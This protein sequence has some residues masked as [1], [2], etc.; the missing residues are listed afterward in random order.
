MIQKEGPGWR[1]ARDE[2][3]FPFTVLIGGENWSCEL[4]YEEWCGMALVVFELIDQYQKLTNQLCPEEHICLE[5]ERLPW[6]GC[7]DGDRASWTL[8]LILQG[9]GENLRGL[10]IC[11]PIP[12]A[13]AMASA[14][15]TMW[16]SDQ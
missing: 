5:L 4:T 14:M 6:W 12:S 13:Q 2:A 8:Q 3:R 1:L 9:N 15:R 10:E 16:D 7:L 11:W